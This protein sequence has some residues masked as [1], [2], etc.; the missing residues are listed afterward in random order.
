MADIGSMTLPPS[1]VGSGGVKR[2]EVSMGTLPST[3]AE[4]VA[5]NLETLKVRRERG[6]PPP[7]RP[8]RRD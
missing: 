1:K 3:K 6:E 5:A 4:V 2:S 8:D 7:G